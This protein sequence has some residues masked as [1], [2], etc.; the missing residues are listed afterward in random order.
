M[1]KNSS[2]KNKKVATVAGHVEFDSEGKG[3]SDSKRAEEILLKFDGFEKI[4]VEAK[5]EAKEEDKE[6]AKVEEEKK[7]PVKRRT[8]SRKA[9]EKNA[10]TK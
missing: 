4:K 8:P 10:T 2:Y 3:T 9:T 6:E 5:E 1:I 7:T